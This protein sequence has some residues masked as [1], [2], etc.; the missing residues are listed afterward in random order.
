[1]LEIIVVALGL[2][3][4]ILIMLEIRLGWIF[5]TIGSALFVV[6]NIQQ[7][8]YMDTILNSY[9]VLMGMYG[10]IVWGRAGNR[11]TTPVTRIELRL[12]LL[13][14]LGCILL[15]A[16][17]GTVLSHYTNNSLPYL[18]AGV[19]ILSFLATWMAARKYIENWILWLIADPLAI[20]LYSAKY[21]PAERWWLY[22]ALFLVY[23]VMAA[24]G[25]YIWKKDL[26]NDPQ[27]RYHRA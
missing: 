7:H 15:T 25:Y 6:S 5:G 20:I 3:Y 22:P 16:G 13:L 14:L 21:Y 4:L 19:T 12:L 23:S 2:I 11:D 1:M 9:Y 24:Y 17:F 18:D 10:W 26:I 27:D 8:L